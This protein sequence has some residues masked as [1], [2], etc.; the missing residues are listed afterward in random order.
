[1]GNTF[2]NNGGNGH[3]FVLSPNAGRSGRT[4]GANICHS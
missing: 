4:S 3:S 2:E 1:M